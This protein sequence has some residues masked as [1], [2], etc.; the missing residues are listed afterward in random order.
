[1]TCQDFTLKYNSKFQRIEIKIDGF[2]LF[3]QSPNILMPNADKQ[4]NQCRLQVHKQ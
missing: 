1:M 4:F 2:F 3:D